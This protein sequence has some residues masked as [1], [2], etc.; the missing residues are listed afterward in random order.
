MASR[1]LNCARKDVS[2]LMLQTA[3]MGNPCFGAIAWMCAYSPLIHL[4]ENT[5]AMQPTRQY[6]TNAISIALGGMLYG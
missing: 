1:D 2:F 3:S 6:D 4:K 5:K